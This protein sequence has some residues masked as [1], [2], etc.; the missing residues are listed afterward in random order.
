MSTDAGCTQRGSNGSMPTRPPAIAARISR[1]DR[2]TEASMERAGLA[3]AAARAG[4]GLDE[5][6][7][8]LRHASV[9]RFL[10]DADERR[11]LV[12]QRVDVLEMRVHDLEPQIA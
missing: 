7:D 3:A 5:K 9:A 2:T 12:V 4:G 6:R 11:E 10:A 8:L 1:S